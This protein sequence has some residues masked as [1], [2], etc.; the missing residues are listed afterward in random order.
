M[1]TRT[2]LDALLSR[3]TEAVWQADRT[4]DYCAQEGDYWQAQGE[5]IRKEI[6]DIVTPE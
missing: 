5:A 4:G 1:I 6:L 2:E 3:Y